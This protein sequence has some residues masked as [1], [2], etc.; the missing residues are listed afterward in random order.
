M[1]V[2]RRTPRIL[3]IAGLVT[4]VLGLIDPLEGSLVILPG[5][6]LAAIG[7]RAGRSPHRILLYWGFALVA[8]GVAALW[9][10]SAMGGIGGSTGRSI[11]WALT[12]LPYPVGWVLSLV[13]AVRSLR[14]T[15]GGTAAP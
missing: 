7:A 14:T 2:S 5:S 9:G 11:W 15:P 4:M 1:P 8:V 3:I 6:M 12:L 10:M 13:G